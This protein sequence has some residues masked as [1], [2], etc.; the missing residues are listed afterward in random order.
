MNTLKNKEVR[1]SRRQGRK[2]LIVLAGC[3][4]AAPVYA[5]P[6]FGF[7]SQTF[8][9]RIPEN[10]GAHQWNPGPLFTLLIQSSSEPW[11]FD[12][13]QGTTEFAPMDSMGRPSQSG[14]H[15]LYLASGGWR[16]RKRLVLR[17]VEVAL[18]SASAMQCPLTEEW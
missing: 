16:S 3:L 17:A 4:L 8:R 11:G 15:D 9:G 18:A 10:V 5:T 1:W 12:V 6:P 7:S 2:V 13:V 14:W